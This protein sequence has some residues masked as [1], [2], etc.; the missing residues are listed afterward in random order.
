[1]ERGRGDRKRVRDRGSRKGKTREEKGLSKDGRA[2][3]DKT[4]MRGQ[5]GEGLGKEGCSTRGWWGGRIG[6]DG[7]DVRDS[8][9]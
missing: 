1:M 3:W 6:G 5:G 2:R 4:C 9:T 7:G 8:A